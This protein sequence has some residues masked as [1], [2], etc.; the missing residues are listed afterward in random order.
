MQQSVNTHQKHPL[1][2]LHPSQQLFR[3]LQRAPLHI[4][5]RHVHQNLP[6]RGQHRAIAATQPYAHLLQRI[7]HEHLLGHLATLSRDIRQ[8]RQQRHRRL[9][10][11]A[12]R[13]HNERLEVVAAVGAKRLEG[14]RLGKPAMSLLSRL[15]DIAAEGGKVTKEVFVANTLKEMSVGLCR[16]NGA[17]L[18]AGRKVL[19]NVTGRDV[20]RGALQPT[21]ELL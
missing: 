9:A 4:P 6:T 19:V 7:R 17:M 13:L 1:A 2:L 3:R 15:A 5:P 10:Q 8:A 20:Q 18:A 14:G 12:E 21:E 11:A 16:G